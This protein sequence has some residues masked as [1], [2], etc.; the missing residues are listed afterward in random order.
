MKFNFKSFLGTVLVITQ[1][2]NNRKIRAAEARS[3]PGAG[4]FEGTVITVIFIVH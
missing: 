2:S 3:E 4:H 1:H